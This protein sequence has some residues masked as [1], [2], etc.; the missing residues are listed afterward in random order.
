MKFKPREF[1]ANY[2]KNWE[3]GLPIASAEGGTQFSVRFRKNEFDQYSRATL[4]AYNV[5]DALERTCFAVTQ[6]SQW[7]PEE[8][9]VQAVYDEDDNLLW[10]DEPFYRLIQKKYEFR[11]IERREFLKHFGATA[12]A[13]LYGFTPLDRA[14]SQMI[15]FAFMSQLSPMSGEQLYT[16][17]GTYTFT[18]PADVTEISV[19]AIGAGGAGSLAYYPYTPGAGGGGGGARGYVNGILTTA[20]MTFSLTVGAGGFA[21]TTGN[22]ANG[23]AGGSST[24]STF[25]TA[26]GGG[27]STAA[28]QVGGAGGSYS[29]TG[30]SSRGGG[31]GGRGG[32]GQW[33][34]RSGGGGGA[35]GYSGDGGQG[36]KAGQND[37]KA[38]AGGGGGGGSGGGGLNIGGM[39]GGG[40]GVGLYGQGA[41]GAGGIAPN[42]HGVGGTGG[43]G[44]Q[45]GMMGTRSVIYGAGGGGIFTS[46]ISTHSC[47]SGAVRIIWGKDRGF[48]FSAT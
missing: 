5:R 37:G 35:A 29:V 19:L 39:G 12:A 16:S 4:R 9:D 30:G 15:P 24:F 33:E 43:S 46:S 27:G 40:G 44:G 34:V 42:S 36:G 32:D 14:N 21:T 3:A 1:N 25:I 7:R 6:A 11:G 10:I 31:K 2:Y 8:V 18:V 23:T 20:G 22:H 13:I 28:E 47:S 26:G 38:G 48:P 41:N 17:A 45:N